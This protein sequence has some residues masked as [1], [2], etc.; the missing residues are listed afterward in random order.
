[1]IPSRGRTGFSLKSGKSRPVAVREISKKVLIPSLKGTGTSL[2]SRISR[3]AAVREISKK[4]LN[5]VPK[6]D[7]N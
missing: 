2:K 5:H 3:P 4:V 6:R 1:M 7:V